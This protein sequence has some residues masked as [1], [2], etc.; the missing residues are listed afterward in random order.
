VIEGLGLVPDCCLVPHHDSSGSK[1]VSDLQKD[2]PG[3]MI[4]GID[5]QTGMIDDGPQNRWNV[6]GRGTV[7]IYRQNSVR[8]YEPGTPFEL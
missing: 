1:W 3:L 6:Y 8:Q 7:T 5:E 2:L 4:I